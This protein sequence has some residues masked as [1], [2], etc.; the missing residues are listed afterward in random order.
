[1]KLLTE[2]KKILKEWGIS[3]EDFEQINMAIKKTKFTV[4][5]KRITLTK[6][7]EI[8]DRKTFL[9]GISRS[10]FHWSCT[11]EGY[12]GIIVSFD[13]SALFK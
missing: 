11:R 6:V 1:M 9:S 8:L 4:N 5:N 7:L 10:A 3:S 13:S 12:K 2:D